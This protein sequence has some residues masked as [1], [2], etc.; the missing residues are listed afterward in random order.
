MDKRIVDGVGERCGVEI[1]YQN[2]DIDRTIHVDRSLGAIVVYG[3][4]APN[5]F[6]ENAT[7]LRERLFSRVTS[8][9]IVDPRITSNPDEFHELSRLSNLDWVVFTSTS[10]GQ[11]PSDEEI[12]RF[13]DVNP[14]V[15]FK[16]GK[17]EWRI[18]E[19]YREIY[20]N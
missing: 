6:P 7:W 5:W 2:L 18:V 12:G 17:P 1:R 3:V 19:Q 20:G 15:H 16:G 9:Y 11:L 13:F 14:H 4:K 10:R 8:I